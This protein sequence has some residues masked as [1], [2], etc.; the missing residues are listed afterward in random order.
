LVLVA[1]SQCA[2]LLTVLTPSLILLPSSG[3]VGARE[4][5]PMALILAPGLSIRP[6]EEAIARV[7]EFGA[8]FSGVSSGGGGVPV[9]CRARLYGNTYVASA[10][11][12][13]TYETI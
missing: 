8:M 4:D 10:G 9:A 13:M 12:I 3:G 5:V 1:A 7:G 11:V 2:R 6:D